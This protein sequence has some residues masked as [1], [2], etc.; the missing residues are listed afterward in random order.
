MPVPP[1]LSEIVLLRMVS[2]PVVWMPPP[3]PPLPPAP[4]RA[5]PPFAPAPPSVPVA[6]PPAPPSPGRL[7]ETLT[8][9]S[10]SVPALRIPPL[11]RTKRTS[12]KPA[13]E[14]AS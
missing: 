12:L 7:L 4:P 1:R 13:V 10:V 6:V 14:A 5:G 3:L 2:G 9:V 8:P 11:R